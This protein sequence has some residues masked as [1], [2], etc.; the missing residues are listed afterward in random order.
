MRAR[1]N[2]RIAARTPCIRIQVPKAIIKRPKIP[3]TSSAIPSGVSPALLAEFPSAGAQEASRGST[4]IIASEKHNICAC[5]LIFW[6]IVHTEVRSFGSGSYFPVIS[7]RSR[8]P[9]DSFYGVTGGFHMMSGRVW[10]VVF[11]FTQTECFSTTSQRR[12]GKFQM[13]VA[14]LC[15]NLS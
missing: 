9:E 4:V 2:Y 12:H 5:I 14:E 13:L 7:S 3:T 6:G 11:I 10:F 8:C 1:P 15:R